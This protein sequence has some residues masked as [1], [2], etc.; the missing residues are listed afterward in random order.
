MYNDAMSEQ[1][2]KNKFEISEEELCREIEELADIIIEGVREQR[3]ESLE[4]F[5]V[6]AERIKGKLYVDADSARSNFIKGYQVLL[7]HIS[8]VSGS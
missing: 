1:R 6:Y 5:D 4:P 2:K 7:G 8:K 3:T